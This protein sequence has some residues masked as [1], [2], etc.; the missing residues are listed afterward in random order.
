MVCAV[1]LLITVTV[2]TDS[3]QCSSVSAESILRDQLFNI[4]QTYHA[5]LICGARLVQSC[6][7]RKPR[8]KLQMV[9]CREVITLF[10]LNLGFSNLTELKPDG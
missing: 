4:V 5:S 8:E 3:A 7:F 2:F 6:L 9:A 1:I 10:L